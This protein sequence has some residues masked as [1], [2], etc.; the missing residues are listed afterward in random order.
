[1][2][3]E[4]SVFGLTSRFGQKRKDLCLGLSAPKYY[5]DVL[6]YIGGGVC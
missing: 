5:D 1:M 6:H 2:T 3:G 4:G